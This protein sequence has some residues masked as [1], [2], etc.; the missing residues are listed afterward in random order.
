MVRGDF[1]DAGASTALCITV[2]GNGRAVIS[3]D[4]AGTDANVE[5]SD[6][7]RRSRRDGVIGASASLSP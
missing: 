7:P 4:P 2:D 3:T 6:D 5:Y 1:I